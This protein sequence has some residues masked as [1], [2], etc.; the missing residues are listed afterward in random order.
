M[1][2]N[3]ASMALH[4]SRT[5]L[6]VWHRYY[7]PSYLL[8]A[9]F[10]GLGCQVVLDRLPRQR[11]ILRLSPLILPLL[12]LTQGW[13]PHDRSD[14]RIAD[15]FSRTL[16]ATLPPGAHLSASDDN[17]L[18][19]L[20]YL[21]LVEGLRPDVDLILQGVGDADLPPLRFD[22]DTDPLYFTHHPNWSFPPL[23]IVPVGLT[24]TTVRAGE[25]VPP[26]V[27]PVEELDGE[28]DPRVPRDYLTQNLIG[29]FH[30]MLG[31]THEVRDEWSRA[32][33]E[34][35][36]AAAAAPHNDV[37][38]YN[39][40][41]IYSRNGLNERALSSF[42]RSHQINPRHIASNR[43]VRAADR[44]AE[45]RRQLQRLA[46]L[47]ARLASSAPAELPPWPTSER[48]LWLAQELERQ[49][50]PLAARG[51]RLRAL[52]A[53]GNP[54]KLGGGERPGRTDSG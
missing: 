6:F 31:V 16:L 8:G 34:F 41:L 53:A 50:E 37:L 18:F 27:V 9:L 52:E 30:Y 28:S 36:K 42:Q 49:G 47:E 48:H 1:A 44:V 22:P 3:L 40:G 54:E 15:D 5:D 29:H 24:F 45:M 25:P 12:L 14:Y 46:V 33:E 51:H 23:Q 13:R 35:E 17:V 38:F 11:T 21:Q 7:L 20:I 39:L 4:G 32:R 26:P 19:V 43:P 10:A 2:A